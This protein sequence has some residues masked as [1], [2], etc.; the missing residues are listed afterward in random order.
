MKTIIKVGRF[1][2]LVLTF[3]LVT[4]CG[5]NSATTVYSYSPPT[6]PDGG[7]CVDECKQSTANCKKHCTTADPQC[8]AH[9]QQKARLDYQEYI[10]TQNATGQLPSRPLVSFY[11]PEQCD[12]SGCGCQ[13]EYEVCYQ[14]CGTRTETHDDMASQ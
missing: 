5:S 14:L 6:S 9:A 13:H 8:L 1:A 12:G 4:G 7:A 11:H 2:L 10:N 3:C